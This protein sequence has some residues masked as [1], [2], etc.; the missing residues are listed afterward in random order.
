MVLGETKLSVLR[1]CGLENRM[2]LLVCICAPE[3]YIDGPVLEAKNRGRFL[4]GSFKKRGWAWSESVE[5]W[6]GHFTRHPL[7]G[8]DCYRESIAKHE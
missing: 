3:K 1:L 5:A 6:R 4:W 8:R 2:Q 7:Y